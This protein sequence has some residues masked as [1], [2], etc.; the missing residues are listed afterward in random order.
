MF[1]L[2]I[3]FDSTISDSK[4]LNIDLSIISLAIKSEIFDPEKANFTTNISIFVAFTHI[5]S[6]NTLKEK[7]TKKLKFKPAVISGVLYTKGL[8][9]VDK[10]TANR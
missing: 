10:I 2:V 4:L 7:A 9:G 8:Q 3:A 6:H 1:I 5:V